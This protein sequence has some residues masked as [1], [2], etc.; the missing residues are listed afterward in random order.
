[1]EVAFATSRLDLVERSFGSIEGAVSEFDPAYVV[2]A[3][4]TSAHE[5][6]VERL[7]SSAF[8]GRLLIEKPLAV[9]TEVLDQLEVARIGVGFNLRF[10]PVLRALRDELA[11]TKVVTI[12]AYAGQHLG[13]WRP[14]RPVHEQYSANRA[15]GGGVLRDLSHELDALAW[16]VGPCAGVFARGGR[17]TEL[18]V[19]SDDA[20]GIVAEHDRCPVVTLQMNYLDSR[21]RRRIVANTDRGTFEADLISGTLTVDERR[22]EFALERDASYRALHEAMLSSDA[23]D[24]ATVSEAIAVDRVVEAIESSAGSR[25][26]VQL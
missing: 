11:H 4:E 5:N 12:E 3:T 19:D 15:R 2:I 13:S 16:L 7:A 17:L 23:R 25:K 6:T 18:T 14:D 10:H 8:R 1:M 9:A 26:W 24:V 20:W 21:T 22:D